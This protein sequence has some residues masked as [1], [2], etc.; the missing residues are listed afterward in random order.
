MTGLTRCQAARA[1]AKVLGGTAF[2]EGGNYDKYTVDDVQG[3]TWSIVYDGSVK[4]VDA[5]NMLS[6]IFASSNPIKDN[7]TIDEI[8]DG[9]M[10]RD[11]QWHCHYEDALIQPP[12]PVIDIY[13]NEYASGG[14]EY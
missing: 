12:R 14:R 13:M 2:H 10:S 9:Q 7:D 11:V 6:Y 3:R 1:I 8:A 5:Y 4:C